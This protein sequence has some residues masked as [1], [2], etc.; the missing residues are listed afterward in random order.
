[1]ENVSKYFIHKPNVNAG[2]V[3]I[4]L[5]ILPPWVLPLLC[6][7]KQLLLQFLHEDILTLTGIPLCF[8]L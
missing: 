5:Y 7:V 2:V 3:Y 4:T 8:S 6:D 1:M